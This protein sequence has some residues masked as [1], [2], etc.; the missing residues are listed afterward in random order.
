MKA[1][2]LSLTLLVLAGIFLSTGRASAEILE[3][4]L[5]N[6][7]I[8]SSNYTNLTGPTT[9]SRD[10][11]L[12]VRFDGGWPAMWAYWTGMPTSSSIRIKSYH[13]YL[14]SEDIYNISEI[15]A[16]GS[17]TAAV[18]VSAGQTINLTTSGWTDKL[19]YNYFIN[20]DITY[21][22]TDIYGLGVSTNPQYIGLN[23]NGY[24]GYVEVSIP[25]ANGI[26][27]INRVAFNTVYGQG[28]IA[29]ATAIPEPSTYGLIGI[30]ALGVAF[31]AR[32]RKIKSA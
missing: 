6:Q 13:I 2:N 28:I 16:F 1:K 31:A 30:G 25:N 23:D 3:L 20:S 11:E 4:N 22:T 7:R 24:F 27:Y 8:Y 14:G 32:R 9:G 21:N 5:N 29:G 18:A 17:G 15:R 12:R 10:V 19:S 26:M